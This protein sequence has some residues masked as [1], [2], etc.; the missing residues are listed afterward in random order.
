MASVFKPKTFTPGNPITSTDL[1]DLQNNIQSVYD[2]QTSLT[3]TSKSITGQ[4]VKI[5]NAIDNGT[6]TIKNLT[7]D[8]KGKTE[9][10][11]FAT[12]FTTTPTVVV[13]IAEELQPKEDLDLA[14]YAENA[15][16]F[17]VWV[18]SSSST[19][20]EIK[21]NYIAISSEQLP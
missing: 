14:A 2:E 7:A 9:P 17:K 11:K 3:N 21:I 13:S 4:I 20:K 1:N 8:T 19:R 12:N 18:R 10:F 15:V 16:D 5:K 6:V